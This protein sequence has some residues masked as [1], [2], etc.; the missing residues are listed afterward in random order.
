M[1]LALVT[2]RACGLWPGP[3]HRNVQCMHPTLHPGAAGGTLGD[4][5]ARKLPNNPNGRILTNQLSVLI[6]LPLSFLLLKGKLAG[7][8][9]HRA[10]VLL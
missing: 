6:G 7:T 4:K 9:V 2:A 5:M 3:E 1:R 10:S 8:A